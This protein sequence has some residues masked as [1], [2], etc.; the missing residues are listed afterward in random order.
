MS[1]SR[2][3]SADMRATGLPSAEPVYTCCAFVAETHEPCVVCTAF[4][5]AP[6]LPNRLLT[7]A[8]VLTALRT[9]LAARVVPDSGFTVGTRLPVLLPDSLAPL[10]LDAVF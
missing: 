10:L 7:A 6:L 9:L 8:L 2:K 5:V 4:P 1:R 3:H